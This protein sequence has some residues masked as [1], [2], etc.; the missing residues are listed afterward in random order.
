[1]ASS[2]I[3]TSLKFDNSYATELQ[4]FYVEWQGADVPAPEL[5]ALNKPLAADLGLDTDALNE[6]A[7]ANIFSGKSA[8]TDAA[9]LAQAY[10]GHQFGGFS[11]QL[12]DGRALLLGE[13]VDRSGERQD[14]ALKG[15]GR[16]P[17]SRGGDGKAVLGPVLREYIMAEAMHALNI[18]TTRALAAVTTGES[19]MREDGNHPGAVLARSAAS[20][21]RVGSFQFFAARGETDNVQK[22]ADYAINRH[23]PHLSNSKTPYLGLLRGV[24]QAQ[25][26]LL[27]K[28]MMVGFVHGVMNTDNM[29]ISGETID[30]GPC[31]FMDEYDPATLFSSIDQQGRYAYGQQP[32]MARWNLAR[33]AETLL[34]L[35]AKNEDRAIEIATEEVTLFGGQYM[36]LWTNRMRAKLG[37]KSVQDDDT[38]LADGLL[39]AM[40]GQNVDYTL[41]FRYLADATL[42]NAEK[43]QALFDDPSAFNSWLSAWQ[44]RASVETATPSERAAAMNRVNPI[45][46]P[47]NHMVEEALQA[48]EQRG[49]YA[50]F[51]KLSAVLANPYEE[52]DGLQE[53]ASPA[54]DGFGPY[55]TF[56][57]T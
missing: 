16:T 14:I 9:P 47:R 25:A 45:Y 5:V 51:E 40:K 20:H 12:G 32:A 34:P 41:L 29:T 43:A 39:S 28:W 27:A 23:Y 31:A 7:L 26:A 54:P 42:G 11:P 13:V 30:Y 6:Q 44:D 8:P 10:A 15:S 18:P 33:F 35:L 56:C 57:G 22:L 38:R 17:F 4:G 2:T 3:D 46:I 37:L 24:R 48:A 36:T 49:N 1:M 50:R 21:L 52:R 19:I 53:Y 55:K